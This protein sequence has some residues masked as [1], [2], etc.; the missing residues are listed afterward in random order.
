MRIAVRLACL[1]VVLAVAV[2]LSRGGWDVRDVQMVTN[3]PLWSV[4]RSGREPGVIAFYRR[5]ARWGAAAL[6]LILSAGWASPPP[7]TVV[8]G[9]GELPTVGQSDP[10]EFGDGRRQG[11]RYHPAA[12]WVCLAQES[13][14]AFDLCVPE[15]DP[16]GDPQSV[17]ADNGPIRRGDIP[18]VVPVTYTTPDDPS[19]TPPTPVPGDVDGDG[20][21]DPQEDDPGFSDCRT[22]GNGVCGPGNPWGYAPGCYV[23]TGQ[24]A[25]TLLRAW[26]PVTMG[27]TAKPYHYRPDG[28][29]RRTARD[30]AMDDR[31]NGVVGQL[32]A[33]VGAGPGVICWYADSPR[34]ARA[35]GP[36]WSASR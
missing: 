6:L 22:R 7:P 23:R 17:E 3:D 35:D 4:H 15:P 26:D 13:Y 8:Y 19:P 1:A 30:R 34:P 28:C 14:A 27:S 12:G 29:G 33:Y 16:V 9:W 20:S 32:C 36:A 31:L 18:S 25:G 5:L 24:R 21:A 10:L 2:I 11:D